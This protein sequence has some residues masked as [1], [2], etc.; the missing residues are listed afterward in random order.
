MPLIVLNAKIE[1]QRAITGLK[2]Q[3]NKVHRE[4]MRGVP[5]FW[6]QKRFPD[7]FK[8]GNFSRYRMERRNAFY[9]NFVKQE[10]G[11]GDGKTAWLKLKGMSER[12]LRTSARVTATRNRATLYMTGPSYFSNP[13][14]GKVEKEITI[15]STGMKRQIRFN[16]KRQPNKP[17]ELT[18]I[19]E[20]DRREIQSFLEGSLARMVHLAKQGVL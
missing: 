15:R 12:W 10:E 20:A 9:K 14:I 3:W 4:A 18:T 19:I 8:P 6:M 17:A 16:I 7:R 13:F 2:G 5:M 1:N 11:E